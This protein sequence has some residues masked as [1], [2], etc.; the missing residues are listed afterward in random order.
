MEFVGHP[1][2]LVVSIVMTDVC[3]IIPFLVQWGSHVMLD[4]GSFR[5]W[6]SGAQFEIGERN[7]QLANFNN[8]CARD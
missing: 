5:F 8:G 3:G 6:S 7:G 4:L 1:H 2:D